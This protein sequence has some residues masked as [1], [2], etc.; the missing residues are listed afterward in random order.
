VLVG[1][2]DRVWFLVSKVA[3]G[4]RPLPEVVAEPCLGRRTEID[5]DDLDLDLRGCILCRLIVGAE[6]VVLVDGWPAKHALRTQDKVECFADGG[7]ANTVARHEKRVAVEVDT[8]LGDASEV[9]DL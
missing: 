6:E 9:L 5:Q 8:P 4:D 7:L 2:I 1:L 3:V